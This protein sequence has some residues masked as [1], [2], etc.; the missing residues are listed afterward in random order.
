MIYYFTSC[1]DDSNSF[2]IQN[3]SF[4]AP[5][6]W[7]WFEPNNQSIS[8]YLSV[9]TFSGCVTYS[10]SSQSILPNLTLYDL[11]PTVN[12]DYSD[13]SKCILVHPCNTPPPVVTPI[14]AGQLN[15]CDVITIMP[16]EVECESSNPSSYG[17]SDGEVSVSITGGTP[18]YTVSWS[19]STDPSIGIHPALYNMPNDTYAATVVDFYGDFTVTVYCKI[20]TPKDCT[21]SASIVEFFLP[22]PTPT[23]T[24]TKTLPPTPTP[25]KTLPPTPTP[26]VTNTQTPGA[27]VT[28]TLTQTLTPSPTKPANYVIAV[29]IN[30]PEDAGKQVQTP[31]FDFTSNQAPGSWYF[32]GGGNVLTVTQPSLFIPLLLEPGGS[33][34]PVDGE[35]LTITQEI[36]GFPGYISFN[37]PI[38][39]KFW[40]LIS[41]VEYTSAQLSTILANATLIVNQQLVAN[42]WRASSF[43]YDIIPTQSNYTYLIYDYRHPP[44]PFGETFKMIARSLNSFSLTPSGQG[45]RVT[46]SLPFRVVWDVANN[47]YTDYQAGAPYLTHSYPSAYTGDILIKSSDLTSITQLSVNTGSITPQ[48]SQTGTRYLEIETSELFRLDGL[49]QYIAMNHFTSGNIVNL[50]PTLISFTA[51]FTNLSGNTIDLPRNLVTFNVDLASSSYQNNSNNIS[52]DISNLPPPLKVFYLGGN[53]TVTGNIA[54]FPPLM[55]DIRVY[56]QN[57]ITNN[58]SLMNTPNLITLSLH[59]LNTVSGD[60]GG[61]SDTVTIIELFGRNTVTGDIQYL[62]PNLIILSVDGFVDGISNGN[63]LYGNIG[64]LPYLT[65]GVVDIFGS[66]TISGNISGIDLKTSAGLKLKGSNEVTGDI[67]TLGNSNVYG[68]ILIDG[69]NT[70]FGNIQGLP[71]NGKNITILGNNEISGDLSL[72]HLNIY[73]LKI[74]GNNT[75]STFSADTAPYFSK[76]RIIEIQSNVTTV[77]FNLSNLNK[78]LTRYANSTWDSNGTLILRGI[79]TPNKYT[80]T[81]SYNIIDITKGVAITIL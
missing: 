6:N 12:D 17:S 47:I 9:G 56:G 59:G 80:N 81:T 22:T 57:T 75:I 48:V 15:E 65:L 35:Q 30:N 66:N 28:P 77:G 31:S 40:Y 43:T 61:I 53:N 4:N 46:S 73:L 26:T 67:S 25:T 10:G 19:S 50:R 39:D 7:F 2:G 74:K 33:M 79:S 3:N 16:M 36:A 44:A 55:T 18:P 52:G 27:S 21:F 78:L 62:P 63:T 14:I 68:S 11:T 58:I 42:T 71:S 41:S 24:P 1:C 76:L 20:E 29:V 13:C 37:P 51:S 54:T 32:N 45:F 34:T 60:L 70:I 38:G 23:M 5:D 69:F 72:V 64:T 49:T 8:Y